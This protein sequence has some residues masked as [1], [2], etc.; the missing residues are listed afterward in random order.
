MGAT[1]F[2]NTISTT[3]GTCTVPGAPDLSFH[4]RLFHFRLFHFR[5]FHFRLFHFRF[6]ENGKSKGWAKRAITK[7]YSRY[8][9]E[10]EDLCVN[11][12]GVLHSFQV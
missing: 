8:L 11:D 6:G 1:A 4:F 12:G 3:P 7:L 10:K 5:L 9:D 2:L